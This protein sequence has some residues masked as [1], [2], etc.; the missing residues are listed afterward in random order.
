MSSEVQVDHRGSDIWHERSKIQ[1]GHGESD[2]WHKTRR[3]VQV[4]YEGLATWQVTEVLTSHGGSNVK[5]ADG[6]PNKLGRIKC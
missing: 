6:S 4:D 5:H 2:T 1:V 3:E